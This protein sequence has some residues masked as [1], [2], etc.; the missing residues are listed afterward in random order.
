[1]KKEY[2]IPK[3]IYRSLMLFLYKIKDNEISVLHSASCRYIISR[4][5]RSNIFGITIE[6]Y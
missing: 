5:I 4:N 3:N 6:K 1:M 2:N